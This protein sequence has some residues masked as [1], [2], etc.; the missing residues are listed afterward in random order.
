[1]C[2]VRSLNTQKYKFF[3]TSSVN[4]FEEISNKIIAS[5]SLKFFFIFSIKQLYIL[6]FFSREKRG[7][8]SS[9]T[10]WSFIHPH[11]QK[12][13]EKRGEAWEAEKINQQDGFP[14]WNE[15]ILSSTIWS[16]FSAT[17]NNIKFLHSSVWRGFSIDYVICHPVSV[18]FF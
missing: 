15:T 2:P 5:L 12:Y 6:G 8:S 4:S 10:Q 1:M 13:E 18:R 17:R 14:F 11:T 7:V 9:H 16:S 3:W